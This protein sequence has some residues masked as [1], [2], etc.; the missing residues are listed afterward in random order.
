MKIVVTGGAGFI[1]SNL[2]RALA[3]QPRISEIVAVDLIRRRTQIHPQEN[4]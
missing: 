2:V 4:R 3:E 1:G